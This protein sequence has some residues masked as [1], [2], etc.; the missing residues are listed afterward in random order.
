MQPTDFRKTTGDLLSDEF[1]VHEDIFRYLAYLCHR[2]SEIGKIFGNPI[3]NSKPTIC[4]KR[5]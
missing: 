5:C 1:I 4:N 2:I 3:Y